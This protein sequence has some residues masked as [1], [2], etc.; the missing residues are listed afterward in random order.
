M[1]DN[2]TDSQKLVRD[3]FRQT[4]LRGIEDRIDAIGELLRGLPPRPFC[5]EPAI[6]FVFATVKECF[7]GNCR[8]YTRIDLPSES[9]AP[10]GNDH[11]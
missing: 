11:A 1:D 10:Q 8:H 2:L 9:I 6:L 5:H 7:C 3:A 4:T